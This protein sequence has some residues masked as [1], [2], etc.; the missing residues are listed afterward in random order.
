MI[1]DIVVNL[2]TDT[3]SDPG[4]D[5]AI[6]VAQAFKAHLTGCAY[7]LEPD[8]SMAFYPAIPTDFVARYREEA[9][10][11]A[12]LAVKRFSEAVRLTG[13]NA[14][15]RAEVATVDGAAVD[16]GRLARL[17][18]VAVVTQPNPDRAGPEAPILEAALI[19]SGRAVLAVPYVQ[20]AKLKLD[21]VLVSWDGGRAA[22]RAV[23]EARPFLERAK[24]VEVV[25]IESG[26]V[27]PAAVPG[28]DLARHLA[29]HGL[30]VELRRIVQAEGQEIASTIQNEVF[31]N[32]FDFLVMGGYGHSRLR[33]FMLGGTTRTIIDSMTVPVLMAH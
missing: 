20:K 8:V 27:D 25:V 12:E 11:S 4:A 17:F 10:G 33:E 22:T 16:F 23:A 14:E 32:G 6:S 7:G 5:F 2:S 1:R 18:D 29:R 3:Q 13:I 24:Q 28:A 9:R 30:K 26:K 21:R 31:E 15:G 19:D